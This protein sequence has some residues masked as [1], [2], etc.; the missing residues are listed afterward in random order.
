MNIGGARGCGRRQNLIDQRQNK[1]PPNVLSHIERHQLLQAGNPLEYII[2]AR[3]EKRRHAVFNR[4]PAN[5]FRIG[6]SKKSPREARR[7][8][9]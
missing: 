2:A 8:Y 3:G 7:S 9:T 4:N 5:L 1:L 6:I